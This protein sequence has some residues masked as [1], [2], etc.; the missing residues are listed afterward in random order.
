MNSKLNRNR[1]VEFDYELLHKSHMCTLLSENVL[2]KLPLATFTKCS[3]QSKVTSFTQNTA[4]NTE[5][6]RRKKRITDK[7]RAD[8]EHILSRCI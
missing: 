2:T 5:K 8:K 7:Y 4:E 3:N 6:A 1:P